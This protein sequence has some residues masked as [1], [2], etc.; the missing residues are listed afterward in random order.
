MSHR[1]VSYR[2]L[3]GDV[4]GERR[5]P[6][7]S[8]GDVPLPGDRP[9]H[10]QFRRFAGCP[11]CD[12]HLRTVARR[13]GE[14]EAAGLR[15]VVV[16]HS[17]AADLAAHAAGLPFDLVADPE[18]RLYAD[19]GVESGARSLVDPRVWPRIVGGVAL[20]LR[21]VLTGRRPMP[22]VDPPGGRFGLPADFLIA[23]DGRVLACRYGVHA[24]DQWSVD[25]VLERAAG[26]VPA[27]QD[28]TRPGRRA[29]T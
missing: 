27:A 21:D 14:L 15:E 25:D 13:H 2:L 3:P 18:K 4:V 11:V 10:L 1:P 12:L 26:A 28:A 22:P 23:T 16:F 29:R 5:L 6:A 19:F 17:P 8:G 9:V 20:S 24:Y 7:I